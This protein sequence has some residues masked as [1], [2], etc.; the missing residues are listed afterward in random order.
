MDAR[1]NR[2][3][4]LIR[5]LDRRLR[6]LIG[7]VFI[8]LGLLALVTPLTPGSW[9]VFVGLE[10]VGIRL[11]AWPRVIAWFRKRKE[12]KGDSAE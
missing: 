6:W 3:M 11:I 8:V 10:L 1:W 12:T 4:A 7:G 5:S 9:L 2:L